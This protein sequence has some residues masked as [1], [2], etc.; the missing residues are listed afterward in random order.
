VVATA[1]THFDSRAGDPQLH[2]HVVVANRARSVSDGTWR[3]LDSRGLFKGLVALSELHQGVLSDLLTAEL[4]WGWDGRS[5]RH[6]DQLRF[7]VT[8]VSEALM[9]EFSQRSAAIEERKTILIDLFAT[10]RGRQPTN[11]EVLDLR[12]RATLETRP[13]KEHRGL[14]EMTWRWRQRAQRYVGDDQSW[15]VARLADRNDLPLLRSFDLA[16]GILADAA[17]V[18]TQSVAERRA[19][20][21][22][23]N[24]LAEVHRQFGGVRFASP[25]ERITTAERTATLATSQSL[26]LSAPQLHHTPELLRR[27][28]GTSRFRARGHEIYTTATVLDAEARLLDTGRQVGGP[29][30][31]EGTVTSVTAVKL[32]G[33]DHPL[34]LDQ[35]TAITQIATSGRSLDVLVG[36]AGSGKTATMA[37]LRA[38]W[39]AH[40]GAGSVLGLAPSAAAAEV[41][42]A[43][44]G[45]DTENVAKWLHEHH[46]E[47]GRLNRIAQLRAELR[48]SRASPRRRS[49]LRRHL[50]TAEEEVAR[51]RLRRGQLV[52][53]EEA[54]LAGTF[55][56]DELVSAA[57]DARA[58]VLLV[59]D[60]AQLSAVEAG[61]AFAALVAD[62][63]GSAPELSDVRRFHQYR[64]APA[65]RQR[66]WPLRRPRSHH[67][68]GSRPDAR[69]PVPGLEGRHQS[70][71]DE[72]DDRR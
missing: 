26:L 50:A 35:A 24:L 15:W 19:T 69:R 21:S 20:F 23:A 4:G 44:L 36:P 12:R 16:E 37:A 71:K 68:R 62:R 8:G 10:A 2:D 64:T 52:I 3:T 11:V 30:V 47:S 1:F 65:Q 34:S 61:G 55:A 60:Q 39:E 43:E 54:S 49:L 72:P 48:S 58:K 27:A 40:Y 63:N 9:A 66:H 53:V 56:L 41:L 67:Q 6:S 31:A 25:H 22:R 42:A 28:D 59:G 70:R 14:A 5:R 32:P 45:M 57:T 13:A 17:R 29:A 46:Q 18:A 7:E 38:V 51:W 33:R